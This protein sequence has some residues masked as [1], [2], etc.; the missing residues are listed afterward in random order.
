MWVFFLLL[1]KDMTIAVRGYKWTVLQFVFL[2]GATLF[3]YSRM[4]DQVGIAKSRLTG[5]LREE[6]ISEKECSYSYQC[7]QLEIKY[8]NAGPDRERIE[9]L[10]DEVPFDRRIRYES[11]KEMKKNISKRR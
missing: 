11:I 6:T 7:P 10:L 2:A 3:L 1:K 5:D 8:V 4:T 9:E